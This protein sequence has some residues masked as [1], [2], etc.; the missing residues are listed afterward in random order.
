L[1]PRLAATVALPLVSLACLAAG[2]QL[3]GGIAD[4]GFAEAGG[5]P[6][7]GASAPVGPGGMGGDASSA[8]GMGGVGATGGGGAMVGGGGAGGGTCDPSICPGI[9]KDCRQRACELVGS[10]TTCFF[11]NAAAKTP[12]DLVPGGV[13]EGFCDGMGICVE[14]LDESTCPD[15]GQKCQ[16]N[17]CVPG[18]C[19][20]MMLDLGKGETDLDC[21]GPC[22]PCG[23]GKGCN[24]PADCQSKF[25]NPA[26]V[27][28]GGGAPAGPA[29]DACGSSLD[30]APAIGTYCSQGSCLATKINGELCQKGEECASTFCTESVC[31]DVSCQDKC[32]SCLA[33]KTM[34]MQN[35]ACG[36][37]A[38]GTQCSA[39]KCVDGAPSEET[40]AG[41]CDAAGACIVGAPQSC[42]EYV[43]DAQ[44]GVCKKQCASDADCIAGHFC[45]AATCQPKLALGAAC[46]ANN[47]CTSGYCTDGVCCESACGGECRKCNATGTCGQEAAGTKDAACPAA[48][49][50]CDAAGACV[51]CTQNGMV[52][53]NCPMAEPICIASKCVDASCTDMALSSGETDVDC[54]G[55]KC[56]PCAN[57]KSCG[58]S[59]QN[60]QSGFCSGGTCAACTFD[61][62]CGAGNY[63]AAGVCKPKKADGKACALGNECQSSQCVDG[64]CCK[65]TCSGTCVA[66]VM[67]K[68]GAADGT[69]APVLPM[70]DPDGEC[71][72]ADPSTCGNAGGCDGMGSCRL[73]PSGTECVAQFCLAAVT[74]NPDLCN[75][76]G[77]CVDGGTISCAPYVCNAMGDA[78]KTACANQAE[79]VATHYCENQV[80][81][82]KKDLGAACT[83]TAQ[84]YEC[85]SGFCVDEGAAG[86]LCCDAACTGA[87]Q[88]CADAK[89][90]AGNGLCADVTSGTDPDMD[91]MAVVETCSGGACVKIH[92][93][94]GMLDTVLGETD[95]DCGG[96]CN[97]CALGEKCGTSDANCQNNTCRDGVCCDAG[98]LGV[99][100]S[101]VTI[102]TGG[103]DGSC[104]AVSAATDPAN[105][106]PAGVCDG[107][108]ECAAGAHV[109]A[110]RFGDG[111]AQGGW[112]VATD[113]GGDVVVGGEYE[114]TID[115]GGG[116]LPNA[117]NVDGFVA[118]LAGN[119]GNQIWAKRITGGGNER[120]LGVA[121]A[122]NGDVLAVGSFDGTLSLDGQNE[123]TAGSEDIFVA[124]LAAG[125]GAKL[126]M[127]RFGGSDADRAN[128]VALSGTDVL[129]AGTYT[130]VVSVGGGNLAGGMMSQQLFVAKYQAGGTHVWSKGY[131]SN[132]D[133]TAFGIAADG[134]GNALVT[135]T[136]RSAALFGNCATPLGQNDGFAMKL[137]AAN[138]AE[139]WCTPVKGNQSEIGRAI[140]ADTSDNVVF[141]GEYDGSPTIGNTTLPS[142]GQSDVFVARLDTN[143]N[144]IWAAGFGN[145]GNQ[146]LRALSVDGKGTVALAGFFDGSINF[147]SG[148]LTAQGTDAWIAK[149]GWGAMGAGVNLW[150]YRF[151]DGSTQGAQGIA[152][153]PSRNL[154]VAGS[155]EGSI[156]FGGGALTADGFDVFVAKRSP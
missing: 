4:M 28:G 128:A 48:T 129:V 113:G 29:C 78:C 76:V 67:G 53:P 104:L 125:D 100:E 11:K 97:G 50:V 123:S 108:R 89:T 111:N 124:R 14:C 74:S 33:S 116:S 47:H 112:A 72:M 77:A 126:W 93:T 25:C 45:G 127:K 155:F 34:L 115:F 21:G 95:V 9:D 120:V 54:G 1:V 139:L 130:G 131:G 57:G 58:A 106:C 3:I 18:H 5:G 27:G 19:I 96:P 56:A 143:G 110:K 154:F 145:M 86:K 90:G 105:E 70:T 91:C 121:V 60:C 20:D 42:Q 71:P 15:P 87:C 10:D 38:S 13:K 52:D 16:L 65:T 146:S 85:K 63:C 101:C 43:C 6:S 118:K 41:A 55:P 24:K 36:P 149:F 8:G 80:C 32:K 148:A 2:C 22:A 142:G 137:A 94:N 107:V 31:C 117:T 141:A 79:C 99:C 84:S 122:S 59:S 136:Y 153:D 61:G 135:G 140:G 49:P 132:Q 75:G 98:C 152:A 114:G 64:V 147:G 44:N 103:S 62:Q 7:Q 23:L 68:T 69:C 151:G 30:C 39:A 46:A 83:G 66:C 134:A 17:K 156:D 92:C 102:D 26:G 133:E 40:P 119:N 82:P 138:G 144:K 73:W 109:W 51:E 150:S 37:I 81:V 35:G 88:A 12:C